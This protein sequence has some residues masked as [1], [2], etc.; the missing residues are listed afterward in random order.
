MSDPGKSLER[1]IGQ[2]V[3]Q[4]LREILNRCQKAEKTIENLQ[5]RIALLESQL[6]DT[7]SVPIKKNSP[8]PN[9][10]VV[11]LEQLAARLQEYRQ[12]KQLSALAIAKQ[13]GVTYATYRSW[14]TGKRKPRNAQLQRIVSLLDG[15]ATV[16]QEKS[17]A[18]KKQRRPRRPPLPKK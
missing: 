2:I 9:K 16:L 13:L 17:E 11:N 12:A 5:K 1:A 14:E 3:K 8:K 7:P 10:A 15:P 18:P 6:A 4:E